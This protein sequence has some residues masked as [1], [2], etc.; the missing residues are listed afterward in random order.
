VNIIEF[1]KAVTRL[2]EAL[3]QP[4]NEFIRDSVI[5]RFE[6]CVELGWKTSAKVLGIS[7][8]ASRD[9]VRDMA[10]A[11]VITSPE[12]WFDLIDARNEA[13]HTYKEAVAEKVYA[14]AKDSLKAFKNLLAE[15]KKR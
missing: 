11:G 6:F 8:S 10:R 7:S 12:T 9:V 3:A 13:S 1:E 14:T 15:L 2:E 4:K 5:Q